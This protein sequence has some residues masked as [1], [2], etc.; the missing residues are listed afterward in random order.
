MLRWFEHSQVYHPDRTL[1]ATGAELDRAW[2]DFYVQSS[3]GVK[4]NGWFFP[5]ASNS[6]RGDLA[7]L[8]CHGNAGNIS[9]RLELYR[10]LLSTGAN[11][12]V[13]DYRGYGRSQGRPSEEGTYRDAQAACHW[14]RHR[15]FGGD[16]IVA[17]GES[18]GGAV[19][20]ELA[21][22][23]TLGGVILQNT[24][25]CIPDVGAELFP[26][27]PVRRWSRIKYDTCGKLPR[28]TVPI[29]IM[30]SRTDELIGFSHCEKN[31]AAAPEPKLFWELTG[32]HNNALSD[33]ARFIAGI[34]Q[35]LQMRSSR[36]PAQASRAF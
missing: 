15:G 28:L 35:F 1:I 19:A 34:E 24:F 13:F 3:D 6:P 26:W 27:L 25:T 22:R 31:L 11:V 7:F 9:H 36:T 20:T 5:A 18:L 16:Q 33:C 29:L 12:L 17:F 8:I 14:L 21:L 10:A 4:L 23:E 30:H 2:E 32:S